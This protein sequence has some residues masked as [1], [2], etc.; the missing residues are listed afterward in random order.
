MTFMK[1]FRS[2]KMNFMTIFVMF[3]V[4]ISV[5]CNDKDLYYQRPEWKELSIYKILQNEGSFKSYL[6]CVDKTEYASILDGAGLYTVFPPNDDAFAEWLTKKGYK[7]IDSIPALERNKIV[8]YSIVYGKWT[9]DHL[10]DKGSSSSN[11]S[12][13]FKRKTVFYTMPYRDPEF[14]NNW[15]FDEPLEGSYESTTKEYQT[16]LT[17]QNY[18]YLPVF[19]NKFFSANTL[20]AE[21]D[22]SIFYP[23]STYSGKNVDAGN[24]ISGDIIGENGVIHVVSTVN[25]TKKNID[26]ILNESSYSGFNNLLDFQTASGIYAFK[27]YT[28][29]PNDVLQTFRL[30]LPKE[31]IDKVYLKGYSKNTTNK[32]GFSPLAENIGDKGADSET[33]GST[34]FVPQ[35]DVLENYIKTKLLKYYTAREQLPLEVISTLINTHIAKELVWNTHYPE[36]K[37]YTGEY[38]NGQGAT[39]KT[40][41]QDGVIDKRMASNGFVYLID[42]VVKSRY[43]ETVYSEVLLNPAHNWLNIAY[44]KYFGTSLREDLMKSVLNDNPNQRYTMLNFSD[45]LLKNDGF[46]YSGEDNSFANYVGSAD[47][48]LK[49]F[50]QLHVFPGQLNVQSAT[51]VINSQIVNFDNLPKIS[52][53][54]NWSFLT[55]LSGDMIRYK[56]GTGMQAAGNI[57]D[58]TYVNVTPVSGDFNNGQVFDV[59]KL[60]QFAPRYS[61]VIAEKDLWTYIDRART[62]NSN[63]KTFVDYLERCL[64][65]SSG[66][67]LAGLSSEGY[68]TI[69][70][71]NNT[72]MTEAKNKGYIMPLDSVTSDKVNYFAQ[73]TKFVNAHILSGRVLPDDGQTYLYP[74]SIDLPDS[75]PMPTLLK[76]TDEPWGLVNQTTLVSVKKNSSG[77]L[78]FTPLNIKSA[79]QIAVKG[80]VGSTTTL[81]IQRGKPSGSTVPNSY[82]SNRIASKAVIHEIN[83][84]FTFSVTKRN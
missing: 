52:Q 2:Y 69:L 17:K 33:S 61:G 28:E 29:L 3:Y 65:S 58:G 67:S 48:R 5:G 4:F 63:V 54:E 10:S 51:G 35:N 71:P 44:S 82:R 43:F 24:V 57:E 20:N 45:Q 79:G 64:K 47:S 1:H 83:N 55:S 34:V 80:A 59:D 42:H 68:Y 72:A 38:I 14:N 31:S 26:E 49:R 75:V 6:S 13:A 53:Y 40:F 21:S 32:I 9:L 30:M 8:A 36:T 50:M 37:N 7:S 39:G 12:G 15:V 81:R 41:E 22:Y 84:F 19:T 23:N 46:T 11:V 18:K 16:L 60:L 74:I 77:L 62:E 73:A 66:N 25:E 27:S 76:I 56:T 70:M 78:I